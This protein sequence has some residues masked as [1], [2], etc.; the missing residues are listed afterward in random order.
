MATYFRHGPTMSM[1][2]ALRKL[3]GAKFRCDILERGTIICHR[4][5]EHL[6]FTMRRDMRSQQVYSEEAILR[7]CQS[8]PKGNAK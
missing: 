1:N 5:E 8:A 7:A 6:A 2:D 3:R 4:G